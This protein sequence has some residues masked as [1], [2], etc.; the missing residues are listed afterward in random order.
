MSDLETLCDSKF[1]CACA[2]GM[3][4]VDQRE[5]SSLSRVASTKK[6]EFRLMDGERGFLD[7]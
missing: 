7:T 1:V 4:K 3:I 5:L 6:H 2:I